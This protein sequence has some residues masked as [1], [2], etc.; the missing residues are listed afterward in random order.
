MFSIC[1]QFI[2][3]DIDRE[4]LFDNQEHLRLAI[5]TLISMFES[6]VTLCVEISHLALSNRGGLRCFLFKVLLIECNLI[7]NKLPGFCMQGVW[8]LFISFEFTGS[9]SRKESNLQPPDCFI[10]SSKLCWWKSGRWA[11]YG[12]GYKNQRRRKWFIICGIIWVRMKMFN[13]L[14]VH[15]MAFFLMNTEGHA[16]AQYNCI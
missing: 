9:A 4:N 6:A 5:L 10:R 3:H 16:T 12:E 2:S 8:N 14:L 1:P 11:Q 13:K 15:V 7:E